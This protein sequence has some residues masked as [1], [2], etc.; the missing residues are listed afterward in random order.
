[1]GNLLVM[2]TKR[3]QGIGEWYLKS[4]VSI[5]DHMK[6]KTKQSHNRPGVAQR[7][8]GGSLSQIFMTFGT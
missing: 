3:Q 2:G 4:L 1:M 6:V 5:A 8:P 7:V